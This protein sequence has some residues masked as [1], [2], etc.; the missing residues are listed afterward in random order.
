[1]LCIQGVRTTFEGGINYLVHRRIALEG[2][3]F[4]SA[5]SFNLQ[6]DD[7]CIFH[8]IS[9]FWPIWATRV[10]EEEWAPKAEPLYINLVCNF[11]FPK[12]FKSHHY[13]C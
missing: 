4:C 9:A 3:G 12:L 2:V 10:G 11:F 7:I 6:R 5:T 13:S 8:Y 1:M